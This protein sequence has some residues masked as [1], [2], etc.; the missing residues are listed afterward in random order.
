MGRARVISG[1]SLSEL[2]PKLRNSK[3]IFGR[4]DNRK[5]AEK[6]H[7]GIVPQHLDPPCNLLVGRDSVV[8]GF[9]TVGC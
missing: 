6:Q 9:S 2:K 5:Y 8:P 7:P 4:D 3:R 1:E